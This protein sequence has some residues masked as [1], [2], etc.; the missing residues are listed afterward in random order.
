MS[1]ANTGDTDP[2]Q[3]RE[4][5]FQAAHKAAEEGNPVQMLDSLFQTGILDGIPRY[6]AAHWSDFDFA[7][8]SVFAAAATDELYSK[9][10]AGQKIRNVSA[11][12]FKVA[13]NKAHDEYEKRSKHVSLDDVDDIA[14]TRTMPSGPPLPRE[15]LKKKA[16]QLARQFLNELGQENVQRVMAIYFDAIDKGIEDVSTADIAEALNLTEDTVRQCRSRGWRR[17]QR[18]A[19]EHGVCLDQALADLQATEE[20]QNDDERA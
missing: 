20:N 11:Y 16:L 10:H 14:D 5:F 15:A 9:V 19:K 13:L 1:T 12:L 4:S 6:I 17:L 18:V 8:A 2:V 3:D 7:D